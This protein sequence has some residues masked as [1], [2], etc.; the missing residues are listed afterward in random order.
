[1]TDS[2]PP[3]DPVAPRR[4]DRYQLW[5]PAAEVV[6]V[7][8]DGTQHRMLPRADGWFVLPDVPAEPGARYA[9]RLDD[10]ELWIPDPRSLSQPDG[11]HRDS[12]VIDPR[13]LA[14]EDSRRGRDLRGA[15]LYEMHVGTFTPGPGGRGGT[16]DSAIERL[17]H[18]VDLGVEA[19]EV[20]PVAS[21][22]GD[23]GWGY[24]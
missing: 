15:V 14:G 4:Y 20:M 18:L 7:R 9:F 8:V 21:F 16:F 3:S 10:A 24:D 2:H 12:E 19:I 17:D 11:V 13:A 1:M 22:P 6:R 5:A 23:R